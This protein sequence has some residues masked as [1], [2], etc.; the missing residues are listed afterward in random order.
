MQHKCPRCFGAIIVGIT[1]AAAAQPD[2]LWIQQVGTPDRDEAWALAPDGAGGVFVAGFTQGDLGG[3]NAGYWDVLVARYDA[4]GDPIWAEQF[5]DFDTDWARGLAS[6]GVGGVYVAGIT[7]GSVGGPNLGGD[8]VFL[9]RYD[10]AGRQ[11]WIT[12]F[13]TSNSDGA[14]PLAMDGVGGVF[15][16]GYTAGSLGGPNAGMYDAFV[17]RYDSE[18]NQVWIKQFGTY[19]DEYSRALTS[20]GAG[21]VFVIGGTEGPLGG[22]Y[23]GQL[24]VFV[25]HYDSAGN[26]TWIKQF[27][28]KGWD[29]PYGSAPDGAGGVYVVGNTGG[30]LGGPNVGEYD[31]FVARYDAAG[32]ESWIEQ[33]GS[34][35][36]DFGTAAASDGAG[37]VFVGGGTAGDLGG[38]FVGWGS[39]PY[40]A[41]LGP[42]GDVM[43]IK[44]FGTDAGD[45]AT[46]L[47]PNGVGGAIMA[48]V[49]DG[50]LGG[51][52]L[53]Q[54]DA[55]LALFQ[56]GVPCYPDLDGSGSLDLDD[57]VTF[58][59][60]FN[61]GD[62]E[63]DCDGSGVLD[64][65]DFFCFVNAFNEG[66]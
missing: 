29:E 13:G 16:A 40:L 45:S 47:S 66:C 9:A 31:V 58:I 56:D 39:D 25:A 64:L 20:D 5:G 7:N 37:G 43:W 11:I 60:L 15:V 35:D 17:A 22:L 62:A 21:G 36:Y 65:F 3:P 55:F 24:D 26:P 44:Q 10:S 49:T 50:S 38:P 54:G 63:A 48:G 57:F 27:G 6:D 42:S 12:Q 14:G 53:G 2:P 23:V 61:A 8:D 46:A 52:Y 51:P 19:W 28:T 34:A 4:E 1:A 18:G 30:N 33:F 41:R 59:I 32:N